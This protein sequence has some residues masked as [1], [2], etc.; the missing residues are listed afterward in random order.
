MKKIVKRTSSLLACL[1]LLVTLLPQVPVWAES[2]IAEGTCGESVSWSLSD[3]GVLTV[4]GSGSMY[5]YSLDVW[6]DGS[7]DTPWY[8]HS[9]L[10]TNVVIQNGVTG[11]GGYAFYDCRN[12]SSITIADSLTRIGSRAFEGCS[13]LTSINIPEGVTSIGERTFSG[14]SSL[15]S[16][17]IPEGVTNIVNYAFS[18][19]SSLTSVTIPDS[20]TRIGASAFEFCSSLTSISI[21]EGVTSIANDTFYSCENLVTVTIP[22]SVT[23][24]GEWA[25]R[26]CSSLT[27]ITIPK[28]VTEIHNR[29]FSGCSSLTAITF[30]GSAPS[31][32]ENV[33]GN[34]TATAH[35]PC[36]DATWIEDVAKNYGGTI[37]WEAAHIYEN[38]ICT[39]CNAAVVV[40]SGI[41]GD[42][43]Y[44][45]LDA[46]GTLTIS[47]T[48][49]MYDFGN[50]YDHYYGNYEDMP[51]YDYRTTVNRVV[52]ENGVENIG[53]YAF[54]ECSIT[55][56][57]IAESVTG[58]GRE[59]FVYCNS[60]TDINIPDSVTSIGERAFQNCCALTA[61]T[62]PAGITTIQGGTFYNCSNL[63]SITIPETVIEITAAYSEAYDYPFGA[64]A[65]CT[66]LT[67]ISIPENVQ[68]IAACT[69]KNCSSLSTLELP[70][71]LN[72]IGRH[73]FY[74]CSSLTSLTLP[75]TVSNIGDRAFYNCSSL[76][77]INI[78]YG[79]TVIEEYSFNGCSSLTSITVPDNVT[80][81]RGG[82]FA[83]C[84][85]LSEIHISAG[86]TCIGDTSGEDSGY[87][88]FANCSNLTAI[89]IPDTVT[90]IGF[91]AFK[92]SNLTCITFLGSA[93]S[94]VVDG[95]NAC[96]TNVTATAYYP[97]NDD[98]WIDAVKQSYG[99]NLTWRMV[100]DFGENGLCIHCGN[101]SDIV[102]RM[103][104][105]D[106]D[107]WNGAAIKVYADGTLLT[108]ATV[109]SG[110]TDQAFIS[111][112]PSKTYTFKWISGSCDNECSFDII[113][114]DEVVYSGSGESYS[115]GEIFYTLKSTCVHTYEAGICTV[116]GAADPNYVNPLTAPTISLKY[117]TVSFEDVILMNV[118]FSAENLQDVVEMGLVTYSEKVTEVSVET[119]GKVIPGYTWSEADG[120]Y[121]VTTAGIAPKDIGNTL[122]FAIYYKLTDGTYGYTKLAGYSPKTYALGQLKTGSPEMKALV[123]AM[124]NYGAAAQTYF[125]YNTD[126]LM[127]AGLTAD[128][129]A[130]VEAYS[131]EMIAAVTQASG[132]KL[133]EFANDKQYTKRYPTISFEGA[134]RINYYFQPTQPVSGDVTMYI[135]SLEDYEAAEV[136]TKENAT[137]AVTMELT[138][139]GEYLAAVDGIAAK[140]LDKATYVT[141]CY[142]DGTTDHCGGVLGYTIGLYCKSQTSKTGALADLAK[143]CA[144]YGYYAGQMFK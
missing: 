31:F 103:T 87:G 21:P 110:A 90:T 117:P 60:L 17:N 54:A 71:A 51:W 53:D 12:L 140:D 32:G 43:A 64:F 123:V 138:A 86:V 59:A 33:F 75:D 106:G 20:V 120:F 15:T 38:G 84:T 63:V 58:I 48:G 113:M 23:S 129:Q 108:T 104:D 105:A 1:L 92:D 56:V 24:I 144:V 102:L 65:D 11:I 91:Y 70:A 73:A 126:A 135:W 101:G 66:N 112:N 6:G 85:N 133:G 107:S 16:I 88:V 62:L 136:L 39:H 69:F 81:I 95:N 137:K 2:V 82:A 44:W 10:I 35:Y 9:S 79:L 8:E 109:S 94:F 89:T 100:H 78:P 142:S 34:V 141:F 47:G 131:D 30:L 28:S 5:D 80:Q 139:T 14:C 41:C 76:T 134:F 130:L 50:Y 119:A 29:A 114:N 57:S 128:Q 7:L 77:D 96:F 83:N 124:L 61:V 52:I 13:S 46:A 98:T 3:D 143:A 127:N 74:G 37:T 118:Y 93:P 55:S 4:S 97:C 111:Y 26:N 72:S 25:F 18:G 67:D 45:V 99:G 125:G 132:D 68:Y 116:C 40:D 22:E 36:G 42:N 121:Y 115:S 27:T 49:R 122:Y 19:C